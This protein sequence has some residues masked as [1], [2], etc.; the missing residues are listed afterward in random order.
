[1]MLSFFQL[2]EESY[3]FFIVKHTLNAI[4]LKTIEI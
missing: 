2:Q 4:L 3:N 1:M